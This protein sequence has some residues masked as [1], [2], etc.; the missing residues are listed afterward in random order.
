MQRLST[1]KI[2]FVFFLLALSFTFCSKSDNTVNTDDPANLKVEILLIDH[3]TGYVQI[4]ATANNAALYQLYIET[5]EDPEEVN[6]TGYFEYT[7]VEQ[8]SHEFTIRAYGASGKY[9]KVIKQVA[10]AYESEVIPLSRGYITPLEYAGHNLVWQDEF[11]G[12]SVNTSSWNFE[13]GTGS[14]GWGNNELEYYRAENA[15]VADSVLTIEAREESFGNSNYTSARLTTQ[16]KRSFQYGRVDIRALLPKGKGIWPALWMLG[17]NFNTTGWPDCGEIDIMEMVGGNGGENKVYGTLHWEFNGE[18]AD[19]GGSKTL[20]SS[21]YN[22]AEAYHV[23][24][25]IWDENTIKWYVDD[26]QYFV[27]DIT[28]SDMSE[29]HQEQFFIFNVAVGGNWP[30]SPDATTIFPQQM[31]V[32]YIRVFQQEQQIFLIKYTSRMDQ[33]DSMKK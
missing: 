15:T 14:G 33:L 12:F 11:D 3:E 21:T 1:N 30:G 6:S 13:I 24:S 28:G 26:Q 8:G 32:D 18:H 31:K 10:I 20:S 17:N 27:I 7:F 2:A 9:V 16:G 19:A 29:F 23:F 5:A 22:F 25:I 4:Q